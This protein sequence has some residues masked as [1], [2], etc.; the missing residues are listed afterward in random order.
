MLSTILTVRQT[1]KP[2]E[3]RDAAIKTLYEKRPTGWRYGPYHLEYYRDGKREYEI[4]LLQCDNG[5]AIL[6]WMF[7]VLGKDW[8]DAECFY[9]LAKAIGVLLSPQSNFVGG[10]LGGSGLPGKVKW[11]LY[12][13]SLP[14]AD[15][16]VCPECGRMLSYM[17]SA[18]GLVCKN[19]KCPN[20]WKMGHGKVFPLTIMP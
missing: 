9:G 20:Y 16:G 8:C 1:M 7:Q 17:K 2:D 13:G 19:W 3:V 10:C 12:T 6:D 15:N 18:S 5:N 4:D 14:S 11:I